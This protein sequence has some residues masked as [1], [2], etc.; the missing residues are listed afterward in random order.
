MVRKIL[1]S[2]PFFA[3]IFLI[4]A[5][6]SAVAEG[7]G[8]CGQWVTPGGDSLIQ[9]DCSQTVSVTLLAVRGNEAQFDAENPEPSLRDR[10]LSGLALGADFKL[11]GIGEASGKLYDPGSGNTYNARLRTLGPDRVEVRGYVGLPAFGRT[12]IWVRKSVFADQVAA[13]LAAGVEQ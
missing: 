5:A 11:D 1:T 12:Q 2:L 8:I 13:M 3:A 9:I 6:G 7:R 10:P 4:Q